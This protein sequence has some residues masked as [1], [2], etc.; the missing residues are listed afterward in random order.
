[1]ASDEVKATVDALT[2]QNMQ[3]EEAQAA[4]AQ[5]T[6]AQIAALI[7]QNMQSDEVKQGIGEA[8]AKA[9]AGRQSIEALKAQLDSY[10]EFNSG[11]KT[12]T[13]GVGSAAAGAGQLHSG[14][15]QLKDGSASLKSGADELKDGTSQLSDGADELKDGI[16][17]LKDGVP[18]LVEGV[19][20]LRNGS[21]Q[22]S[23]GLKQ[24]NEE[25][26]SKI[27]SLLK[28]DL[29]GI[30]ERLKATI[31]VSKNYKSYSGLAEGMDGDVK[32]LYK[33]AE[34]E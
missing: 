2:E 7:E 9:Q 8:L 18:S 33:T 12:Y 32:F 11:L 13:G 21:M 22:L 10:S 34:V 4:I 6:E 3:G 31:K 27:T 20:K 24:L 23:D 5:N 14:T 26:I 16:L 25:G 19:S 1:M 28:G 15:T 30:A 29:K 17:T